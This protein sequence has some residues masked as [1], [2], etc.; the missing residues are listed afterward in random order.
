MIPLVFAWLAATND[1]LVRALVLDTITISLKGEENLT[2]VQRF[3]G[4]ARIHQARDHDDRF[5]ICYTVPTDS[6]TLYLRF[7]AEH[8]LGGPDH[9]LWGF[10]IGRT[11]PAGGCAPTHRIHSI[12]TDNHLSL[13]MPIGDLLA[14]MGTPNKHAGGHYVFEYMESVKKPGEAEYDISGTLEVETRDRR[15]TALYAIYVE[16]T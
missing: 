16:T 9:R 12:A 10:R 1:S 4:P 7:E 8:D 6:G 15:V 3:F 2:T 11:L 5:W 14:T 13:G